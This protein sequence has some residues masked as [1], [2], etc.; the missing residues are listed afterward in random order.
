MGS[1]VPAH[2]LSNGLFVSGPAEPPQKERTPTMSSRAVPYTGG[3]VKTSGEL[4]KMFDISAAS[5]SASADACVGPTPS[6]LSRPLTSS[7]PN[8]GSVRS[9]PNSGSAVKKPTGSGPAALQPTGLITSGSLSGDQ[10][11]R[12]SGPTEGGAKSVPGAAHLV[13]EVGFGYRVPKWVVW[14]SVLVLA[15]AVLGGGFVMVVLKKGL[16]L[17]AVAVAVVAPVVAVVAWNWAWGRRGVL[18]FVDGYP[19]AE[20]RSAADGQYV[21]VTGVVTCGS[22]SL[23]TSY[24]RVPR[25]VYTSSELFEYRGWGGKAANPKHR[26]FTW[27]SRYSERYVSDFYISDFQSGLRALV[28]SGHGAKVA[29]FVETSTVVDVPKGGK[30]LSPTFLQWLS[31]HNLSNDDRVMRLKEGYIKEGSTVSVMGTVRRQ[32][33]VLMIVPPS[34]PISTGCRWLRC[35]LPRTVENLILKCDD[36]QDDV[37]PV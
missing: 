27:G 34:E 9:G 30:N 29:V 33:N 13:G 15:A 6:K 31:H 10:R 12:R 18:G 4:G 11:V 32:D 1:R 23:E 17:L 16:L 3:D 8:S 21:K 2:Q 22:V 26:S 36:N 7:R 20:L 19:D 35:L 24:Q 14:G 37:I 28:K 25:C 5:A